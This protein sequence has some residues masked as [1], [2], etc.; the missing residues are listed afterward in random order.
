MT[1]PITK[2]LEELKSS[3]EAT[4]LLIKWTSGSC[5]NAASGSDRAAVVKFGTI[6]FGLVLSMTTLY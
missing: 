5:Q 2:A 3:G 4:K 1:A 6:V